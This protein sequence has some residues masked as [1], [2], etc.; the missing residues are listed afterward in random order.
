MSAAAAIGAGASLGSAL[1][2]FFSAKSKNRA[3]QKRLDQQHAFQERMSSTAYQRA[4]ADMRQAGLNPIL[5]YKQGGASA[6]AGAYAPTV[7]ELGPAVNSARATI[8]LKQ[9]IKNMK[10]SERLIKEQE[11]LAFQDREKRHFETTQ[12]VAQNKLIQKDV[13][14]AE[15]VGMTPMTASSAAGL[16]LM[17]GKGLGGVIK[18][19]M[20]KG[21]R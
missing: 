13:N 15:M 6:P 11:R 16:G 3:D 14:F 7:E 18:A 8:A 9:N 5:A 20:R 2:S 1:L 19:F 17:A 4:M 12:V 10:A 21:G